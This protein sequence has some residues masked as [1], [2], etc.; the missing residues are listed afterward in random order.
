MQGNEK[1]AKGSISVREAGRR[2]GTK[3]SERH[4]HDFYVAIGNKGGARV[5]ELIEAGKKARTL[6]EY[7]Q[8]EP[9]LKNATVGEAGQKGGRKVRDLIEEGK[10]ARR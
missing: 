5:K 2:G 7:E 6:G 4:G 8:E 3:T 1:P 10:R 9:R